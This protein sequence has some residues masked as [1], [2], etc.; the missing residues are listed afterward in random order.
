MQ[1]NNLGHSNVF[2][3]TQVDVLP[4]GN[5]KVKSKSMRS[6]LILGCGDIGIELGRELL[7]K[8]FSVIGARRNPIAL[9]GTGIQGVE[10]DVTDASLVQ[11]LPDADIVIY[12]LAADR[13][14]ENAYQA[15]YVEGLRTII[16]EFSAREAKPKGLFFVSSTSVY[17]QYEGETVDETSPT[18]P[19]GFAG[20]IIRQ[21]EEL[22]LTS[23]LPGTVVRFSGIYGPGRDG[24]IRQVQEGRLAPAYPKLFTNRIHR[25]DCA[26]VLAHL[27][28]LALAGEK[29][30]PIY[31]AS[32]QESATLHDVMSWIAGKI[33]VQPSESMQA[34]LRRRASKLC[35]NQRLLD[36]GYEFRYPTFREGYSDV[37]KQA[38][39]VAE[40]A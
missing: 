1:I 33:K 37:L 22:L 23:N 38:G 7:A 35:S 28:E 8:N 31:L 36:S 11:A 34:P 10:I 6:V 27:S 14:D 25:D 13:F 17:A 29:L 26:G 5:K 18:E 4:S 20:Q 24:L 19:Q 9:D 39:F 21:A 3:L 2:L 16:D 12:S 30:E 32:D 40:P 15:A